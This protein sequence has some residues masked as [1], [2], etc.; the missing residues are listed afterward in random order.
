MT[1]FMTV[2]L[3]V[4]ISSNK[5]HMDQ[6]F[7]KSSLNHWTPVSTKTTMTSFI[8]VRSNHWTQF[9]I[10]I[11]SKTKQLLLIVRWFKIKFFLEKC[12]HFASRKWSVFV[13]FIWVVLVSKPAVN[14]GYTVCSHKEVNWN[15]ST[16]VLMW[17]F[18]Q[19]DSLS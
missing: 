10:R 8:P 7:I 5:R 13:M 4:T 9:T 19:V 16:V 15:Q 12:H 3:I 14:Y 6:F 18:L 2:R 1:S 11:P 17:Y